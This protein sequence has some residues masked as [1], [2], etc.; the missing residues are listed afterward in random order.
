MPDL[1]DIGLELLRQNYLRDLIGNPDRVR[2]LMQMD[3]A[4][5]IS[6]SVPRNYEL[7]TTYRP[8]ERWNYRTPVRLG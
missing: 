5:R 3:E 4:Q 2:M 6:D 8:P 1:R 7:P